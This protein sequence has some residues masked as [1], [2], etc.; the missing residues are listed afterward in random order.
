LWSTILD[1]LKE[2]NLNWK[3]CCDKLC[4]V[5]K[6]DPNIIETLYVCFIDKKFSLVTKDVVIDLAKRFSPLI[7]SNSDSNLKGWTINK[8]SQIVGFPWFHGKLSYEDVEKILEK[9]SVE[10]SFLFRFSSTIGAYVLAVWHENETNNWKITTLPDGKLEMNE[11]T[12]DSLLNIV[13]KHSIQP[14]KFTLVNRG[15][16]DVFLTGGIPFVRNEV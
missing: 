10:G 16:E 9:N 13:N 3:D 5:S 14:L 7:S 4:S 15:R 1:W 2:G 8:I 11:G 6:C 12:Y